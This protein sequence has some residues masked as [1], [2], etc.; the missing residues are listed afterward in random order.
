[1]KSHKN[2][3]ERIVSFDNLLLAATKAQKCKRFKN[4]V[5]KFNFNLEKEL[6]NLQEELIPGEYTPGQYRTFYVNDPKHRKI[7][8][9][10]YRDR[11]I[12]HAVCNIFA[13][14]WDKA[15]IF[16]SYACREGKG[17][18]K[19]ICRFTE[20]ARKNNYVLKCDI[21]K[22]FDSINHSILK[23]FLFSRIKENKV[24]Y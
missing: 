15:M 9:A 12:H 7:S 16:D 21:G 11:V 20:F 8:A 23:Y 22:F 1:M 19:A 4:E 10:P 13:P 17:T 24:I 14:L 2:L 6:L 5:L 18:H 3:F